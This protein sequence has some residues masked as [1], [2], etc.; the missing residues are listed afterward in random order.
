M[1]KSKYI[2]FPPQKKLL[3]ILFFFKK[4]KNYFLTYLFI[5]KVE[6]GEKVRLYDTFGVAIL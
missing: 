6:E 3:E 2:S 4:K 5:V 1:S